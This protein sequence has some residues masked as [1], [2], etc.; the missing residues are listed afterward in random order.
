[1]MN[2]CV[3]YNTIERIGGKL[4]ANS[5]SAYGRQQTTP[6]SIEKLSKQVCTSLVELRVRLAETRIGTGELVGL[7]VGDIITTQK[8]VRSP[9]VVSIEGLPKFHARPGAIK[10]HKAIMI[11]EA[12]EDPS[13]ALGN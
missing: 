8:D 11:E 9:L 5:W 6:E 2:L 10:G 13:Q 7:R 12:L 3:P 1:M 4:S